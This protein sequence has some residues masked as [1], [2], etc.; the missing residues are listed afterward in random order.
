MTDNSGS[1]RVELPKGVD[2]QTRDMLERCT[3]HCGK[4]PGAKRRSRA[5]K[6]ISVQEL[7]GCYKQFA[8]AKHLEWK[9]WIDK[10]VFDLIDM[11]KVKPK[12]Y[13]TGRWV[14]TIKTDKQ[15]NIRRAKARWVLRGILQTD[16]PA[17]GRPGFRMSCQMVASKSWDLFHIDLKTASLQGQSYDVNRDVVCQLPTEAGHPPYIAARLMK[18][19][20]GMNDALPRWWNILD[21]AL[22]TYGM[23]PTRADRCCYVLY[24]IQ[25]RERAREHWGQRAVAQQND[26]KDA[27]TKSS[28]QSEVEAAFETT[29]DPIAGSPATGNPWQESS[30][31]LW[32]ISLEQ[33]ETKWNNAF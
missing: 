3:V 6:E 4:A 17:S 10:E 5:R 28:E 15:G 26:T 29:L 22:R 31:Y 33:V 12:N 7:R 11:K 19:A 30:I 9:S 8:E 23:I 32:M 1:T 20:D 13:V 16:S 14:L 24:S 18:P 27:F 2:N 21:T 25:S